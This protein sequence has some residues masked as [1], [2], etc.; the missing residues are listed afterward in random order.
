MDA[1]EIRALIREA[2]R[3]D[4]IG[5]FVFLPLISVLIIFVFYYW[6]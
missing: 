2:D 4:V 6:G 5:V 1:K 3:E